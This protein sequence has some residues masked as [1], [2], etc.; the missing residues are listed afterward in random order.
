MNKVSK[1]LIH[2]NFIDGLIGV[3][4]THGVNRTGYLICRYL[5]ER[6]DWTPNDA[7]AGKVNIL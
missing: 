1:K 4:C 2:F 6:L 7:I 5:I 3:H